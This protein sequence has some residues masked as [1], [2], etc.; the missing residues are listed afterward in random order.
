MFAFVKSNIPSEVLKKNSVTVMM[1]IYMSI[2]G[3]K[4]NFNDFRFILSRDIML[5]ILQVPKGN[6]QY[7]IVKHRFSQILYI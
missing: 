5:L 1:K 4:A 3:T 7:L 6:N 2:I